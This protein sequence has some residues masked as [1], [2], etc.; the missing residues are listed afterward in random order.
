MLTG[1]AGDVTTSSNGPLVVASLAATVLGLFPI[2]VVRRI[3]NIEQDEG[4]TRQQR[5]ILYTILAYVL[6]LHL[7]EACKSAVFGIA[8]YQGNTLFGFM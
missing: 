3:A 1:L 4:A 7:A 2:V 6:T 8:Y 5:L